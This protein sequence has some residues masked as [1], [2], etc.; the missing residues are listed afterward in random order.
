MVDRALEERHLALIDRLIAEGEERSR[1]SR[2]WSNACKR[3]AKSRPKQK[4]C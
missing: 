3:K 1:V 2:T 4:V